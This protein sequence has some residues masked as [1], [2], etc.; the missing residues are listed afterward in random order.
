M[1]IQKLELKEK[2]SLRLADGNRISKEK[3]KQEKLK[4]KNL[5]TRT[6]TSGA[7]LFQQHY[8]DGSKSLSHCCQGRGMRYADIERP[9]ELGDSHSSLGIT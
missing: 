9:L 7:S 5:G 8:R 2:N 3:T 4:M 1:K 6:G